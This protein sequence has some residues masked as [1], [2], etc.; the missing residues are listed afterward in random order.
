MTWEAGGET[1]RGRLLPECP[2]DERREASVEGGNRMDAVL[3]KEVGAVAR[4]E[5]DRRAQIDR[6]GSGPLRELQ[7]HRPMLAEPLV[8]GNQDHEGDASLF[9]KGAHGL[10]DLPTLRLWNTA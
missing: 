8:C 3:A 7:Q 4:A 5:G 2:S 9:E 1:G 6:G 10:Q